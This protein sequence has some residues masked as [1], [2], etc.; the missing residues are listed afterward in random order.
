M[1]GSERTYWYHRSPVEKHP[2]PLDARGRSRRIF[3][4]GG[5]VTTLGLA[6]KTGT[7]SDDRYGYTPWV[8]PPVITT[9]SPFL[10]NS[11]GSQ[12]AAV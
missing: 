6:E 4:L 9:D 12:K 10:Y 7:L 11:V 2:K 3:L 8:E 5:I 1:L